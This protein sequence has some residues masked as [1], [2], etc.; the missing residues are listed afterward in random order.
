VR[1]RFAIVALVL[2][3]LVAGCGGGTKAGGR[4]L[5]QAVLTIATPLRSDAELDDYVAAVWRLSRGSIRLVPIE[6]WRSGTSDPG[7]AAFA[8]V[9]AGRVDLGKVD[10]DVYERLGVNGFEALR[11]PFLIGQLGFE[12]KLLASPLATEM[13]GTVGRLGVD[14]IGM[15]PGPLDHPFGLERPILGPSSYQHAVIGTEST[16]LARTTFR[17]LGAVPRPFPPGDLPPWR[18]A[19]GELDLPTLLDGGPPPVLGRSAV[20]LNV[21]FWPH[22]TTIVGNKSVMAKLTAGQR[23]VLRDAARGALAPAAS[24]LDAEDRAAVGGLCHGNRFD[25]YIVAEARPAQLARL[26]RAVQPVYARLARDPMTRALIAKIA[27]LKRESASP[28]S[29]ACPRLPAP[30]TGETPLD[31]TWQMTATRA[32]AGDDIDAGHYA[33]FL[34]HG[35]LRFSFSSPGTS[36]SRTTGV[37]RLEGRKVV[38]E[39]GDGTS[40]IYRWNLFRGLLTLRRVPGV[41]EAPNPTFAPWHRVG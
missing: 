33:L 32:Q 1:A 40:S 41:S 20:T 23:R 26:R 28:P 38:F 30:E 29:L 24:H 3:V 14:G 2:P 15:L 8:D 12:E 18:Y 10:I 4:S 27:R 17:L 31:G 13:L 36:G 35:R 19:G 5:N 22:A 16:P 7:S 34:S 9:R 21:A 11:A 6:D 39:L 37:F 25:R